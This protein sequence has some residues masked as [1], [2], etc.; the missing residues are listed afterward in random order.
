MRLER[1]DM[2]QDVSLSAFHA[3]PLTFKRTR[4]A[5]I[6]ESREGRAFMFWDEELPCPAAH[7]GVA[8]AAPP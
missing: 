3:V 4:V 5:K 6:L 1:D 7:N 2:R 8:G